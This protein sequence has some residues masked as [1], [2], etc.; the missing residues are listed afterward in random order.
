MSYGIINQCYGIDFR[1][2]LQGTR[3]NFLRDLFDIEGD[4]GFEGVDGGCCSSDMSDREV[5]S[6][7]EEVVADLPYGWS[8]Y[9]GSGDAPLA[10]GFKL[11]SWAY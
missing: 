3:I 6:W 5:A 4:Q 1:C 8:A 11:D 7:A 2:R 9:S 10:L